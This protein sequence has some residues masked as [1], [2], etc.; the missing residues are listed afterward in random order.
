MERSEIKNLKNA[1]VFVKASPDGRLD[2]TDKN[3]HISVGEYCDSQNLQI[4]EAEG[5]LRYKKQVYGLEEQNTYL[6]KKER[7]ACE[8]AATLATELE[9]LRCG[10]DRGKCVYCGGDGKDCCLHN[11]AGTSLAESFADIQAELE[12]V[13][14]ERDSLLVKRAMKIATP[15]I[16]KTCENV[17]LTAER[18]R[19]REALVSVHSIAG[20]M[21]ENSDTNEWQ[22]FCSTIWEITCKALNQ[23]TEGRG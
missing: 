1:V 4:V 12:K 2:L 15:M 10:V 20:G 3:A 19:L 9:N 16:E 5:I 6:A 23:D 14:G 11:T 8:R 7:D 17:R 22:N 18:D 21:D 13:K